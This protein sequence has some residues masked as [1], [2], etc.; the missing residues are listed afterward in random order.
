MLGIPASNP[1]NY[2]ADSI[3][4]TPLGT[5]FATIKYGKYKYISDSTYIFRCDTSSSGILSNCAP[6]FSQRFVGSGI[7]M[8]LF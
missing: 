5:A 3:G 1:S 2:V 6:V 7:Y 4:N 8:P